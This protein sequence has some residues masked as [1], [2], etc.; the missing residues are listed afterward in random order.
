MDIYGCNSPQMVLCLVPVKCFHK[1]TKCQFIYIYTCFRK[2][3]IFIWGNEDTSHQVHIA[4]SRLLWEMQ[5]QIQRKTHIVFCPSL[6][7]GRA[8]S[9]CQCA[10]LASYFAVNAQCSR[11]LLDEGIFNIKWCHLATCLETRK[12]HF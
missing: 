12:Y 9:R 8:I 10:V 5:I 1:F 6:A 3:L 11:Q 4:H 7:G 2:Y